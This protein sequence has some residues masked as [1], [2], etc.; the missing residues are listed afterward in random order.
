MIWDVT[1]LFQPSLRPVALCAI[2]KNERADLVHTELLSA[3]LNLTEFSPGNT[4]IC[5]L[6]SDGFNGY[7]LYE[8]KSFMA[9]DTIRE[10]KGLR[11]VASHEVIIPDSLEDMSWDLGEYSFLMTLSK[12]FP[13]FIRKNIKSFLSFLCNKAGVDLEEKKSKMHFVIHPGGPKIID[14]VVNEIGVE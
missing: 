2:S 5:S 12:R 7:S 9:D 6:F 13:V 10:K 1:A 11:I 3:H 4:M 8:E 14:Y